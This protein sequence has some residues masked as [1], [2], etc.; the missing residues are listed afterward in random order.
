MSCET[1]GVT[2]PY[3]KSCIDQACLGKMAVQILASFFFGMFMD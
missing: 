2:F 1:D 3:N